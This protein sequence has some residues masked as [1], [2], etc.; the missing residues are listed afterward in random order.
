M[1][2]RASTQ[3]PRQLS[4]G[5][6]KVDRKSQ[7]FWSDKFVRELDTT[8]ESLGLKDNDTLHKEDFFEILIR[9]GYLKQIDNLQTSHVA[10]Q[11]LDL[12]EKILK[13]LK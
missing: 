6:T 5:S 13:K 7:V 1:R 9:L 10:K 8:L 4:T 12:F 11:N 2:E 3:Y